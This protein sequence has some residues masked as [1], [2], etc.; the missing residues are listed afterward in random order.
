MD[1]LAF[2]HSIETLRID[3]IR[4]IAL[5]LAAARDS[6]ADDIEATRAVLHV[7][8]AVRR[9]RRQNQAAMAALAKIDIAA[10]L[11]LTEGE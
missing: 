5:H 2:G 7:E 3:D 9:T 10:T 8:H 4:S 1:L 11:V 6:I